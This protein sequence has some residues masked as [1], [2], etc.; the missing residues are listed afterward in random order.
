MLLSFDW[1]NYNLSADAV[2]LSPEDIPG[3]AEDVFLQP[4]PMLK[5]SD[6]YSPVSYKHIGGKD[7]TS[8]SPPA[9]RNL[10]WSKRSTK[11]D[12]MSSFS[13]LLK[14]ST[15]RSVYW[16]KRSQQFPTL[17]FSTIV[18]NGKPKRKVYWNTE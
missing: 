11:P 14:P 5:S 16:S 17:P 10:Y 7:N 2:P 13:P 6:G 1:F 8:H 12:L 15:K 4:I 18:R 9:K 3:T